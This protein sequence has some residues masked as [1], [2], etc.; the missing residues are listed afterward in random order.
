MND[1]AP[2]YE[3]I[4]AFGSNWCW[5]D[6]DYEPHELNQIAHYPGADGGQ[7]VTVYCKPIGA[8]FYRLVVEAREDDK[9]GSAASGYVLSGGSTVHPQMLAPVALAISQGMLVLRDIETNH[10]L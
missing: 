2:T 6:G 8:H 3:E 7:T 4:A 9:D 10:R 5:G 1:N